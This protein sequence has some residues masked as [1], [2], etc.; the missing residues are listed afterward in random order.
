MSRPKGSKNKVVNV[1]KMTTKQKGEFNNVVLES[2]AFAT[3]I[4]LAFV[5]NNVGLALLGYVV[6]DIMRR[7]YIIN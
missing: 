2:L 4:F 6:Y 3:L 1:K 5:S 7:R